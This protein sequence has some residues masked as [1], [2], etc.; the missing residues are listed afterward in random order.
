MME[1][2]LPTVA[3]PC[4]HPVTVSGCP[5]CLLAESDPRYAMLFNREIGNP[6]PEQEARLKPWLRLGP[7]PQRGL[8]VSPSEGCGCPPVYECSLFGKVVKTGHR[9]DRTTGEPFPRCTDCHHHPKG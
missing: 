9:I 8:I 3:I 2:P 1:Q 7:C 5:I 4:G 6:T